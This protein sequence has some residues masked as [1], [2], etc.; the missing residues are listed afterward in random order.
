M[1]QVVQHIP[2]FSLASPPPLSPLPPSPKGYT[3]RGCRRAGAI[4]DTL[5][6]YNKL[7]EYIPNIAES[8]AQLQPNG[9]VRIEQVPTKLTTRTRQHPNRPFSSIF[10]QRTAFISAEPPLHQ[11][12]LA[13]LL[14]VGV[15]SPTLN[16]KT[17]IVLEVDEEPYRMLTFSKVESREFIEFK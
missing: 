17:K 3:Y 16:L 12:G 15:I 13:P 4:W 10:V 11:P 6:N 14:Q 2:S 9:K 7:S 5:T 8:G 1:P